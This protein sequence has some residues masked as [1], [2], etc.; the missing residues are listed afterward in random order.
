M[1]VA[2]T[3]PTVARAVATGA[4]ASSWT[5]QMKARVARASTI[6]RIALATELSGDTH[7]ASVSAGA[8]SLSAQ[9]SG[10]AR[11]SSFDTTLAQTL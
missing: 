10:D 5:V 3:T 4:L 7:T 8:M 11:P 2:R 1:S 6:A 9:S